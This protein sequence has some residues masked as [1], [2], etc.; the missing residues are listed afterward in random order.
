MTPV[1]PI[2]QSPLTL[3]RQAVDVCV[4]YE[5][6]KNV[7]P[8]SAQQ[9]LGRI[10]GL[11]MQALACLEEPNQHTLHATRAILSGAM[12][13]AFD[14]LDD[15]DRTVRDAAAVITHTALTWGIGDDL[16]A[17]ATGNP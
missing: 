15:Q 11:I 17:D 10:R 5:D 2:R 7:A 1:T 6:T 16:D 14:L 8:E 9:Q 12:G 13:D 3:L 4:C